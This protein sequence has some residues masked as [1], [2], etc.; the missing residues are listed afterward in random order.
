MGFWER[1]ISWDQRLFTVLNGDW[2]NSF[3]DSI[4]PSLRTPLFWAP[5]YLFVAVFALLN[6]RGKG[7]WWCLFFLATV[8]L[9]DMAGNYGFK[10][11]FERLRPCNDP[12]MDGR[13]RLLI[14]HCGA[15]YSFVSNHAANHMGMAVFFLITFKPVIGKWAWLGVLWALA[16]A[17]A[18]VYC[19]VH[20]PLDIMGGA[21]LG[22]LAGCITGW[23][24]QERFKLQPLTH[25][26]GN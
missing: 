26:T 21:I 8:A 1:I 6:F 9:T 2:A 4:M 24:F 11:V 5:L 10:Q 19:G 20:Y 12:D 15:G 14:S 7:A 25:S 22:V 16:V 23:L 17:Y 13:V 3:F 18:Q